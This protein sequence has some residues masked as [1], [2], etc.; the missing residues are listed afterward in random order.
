MPIKKGT[1]KQKQNRRNRTHGGAPEL[2]HGPDTKELLLRIAGMN[3][4]GELDVSNLNITS[5]PENPVKRI[6]MVQA[7]RS[8]RDLPNI[9]PNTIHSLWLEGYNGKTPNLPPQ[10]Q[11]LW[12]FKCR[13]T[14]MPNLPE[15]LT[16]LDCSETQITELPKLPDGLNSL[17]VTKCKNLK[18]LPEK[19]PLAL[20]ELFCSDSGL[21]KL[22]ET[23]P[24]K[25]A[26]FFIDNTKIRLIP[27]MPESLGF[28]YGDGAPLILERGYKEPL[29][30]YK[31]RW[32]KWWS[33]KMN[34]NVPVPNFKALPFV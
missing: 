8:D 27:I 5:F 9:L 23:L 31:A 14:V 21:E 2:I 18:A 1:K 29:S 10:L 20:T 17:H 22:P 16:S 26:K 15:G 34:N 3:W 24:P 11:Q 32:A 6:G 30:K 19:L 13:A 25:L 4:H 7:I 28:F 33:R 12:Y